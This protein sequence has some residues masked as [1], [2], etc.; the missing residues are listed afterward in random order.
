MSIRI[1]KKINAST[2]KVAVKRENRETAKTVENWVSDFRTQ[3][4]KDRETAEKFWKIG[5]F[6]E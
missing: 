5:K 1:I 3:K 4:M 2:A 6:A